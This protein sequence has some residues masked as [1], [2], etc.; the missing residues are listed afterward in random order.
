MFVPLTTQKLASEG[1][2]SCLLKQHF[3]IITTFRSKLKSEFKVRKGVCLAGQPKWI[4]EYIE[5]LTNSLV[6]W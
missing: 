6:I 1:L 4:A 3:H 5:Y 2:N